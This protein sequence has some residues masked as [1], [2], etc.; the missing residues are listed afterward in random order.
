MLNDINIGMRLTQVRQMD[1]D[2][3]TKSRF[4]ILQ[5]K[6][7]R[8]YTREWISTNIH[9]GAGHTWILACDKS[10]AI[11]F[12]STRRRTPIAVVVL[13]CFIEDFNATAA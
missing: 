1:L 6:V 12:I 2:T 8:V 7:R 5:F 13:Q 3:N 10:T 11:N 4:D 9:V